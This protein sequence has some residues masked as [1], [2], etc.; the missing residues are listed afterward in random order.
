MRCPQT[1]ENHVARQAEQ[2]RHS[3]V[4]YAQTVPVSA[5]KIF[6]VALDDRLHLRVVL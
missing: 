1:V 3:V 6:E 4:S 2:F 5:A